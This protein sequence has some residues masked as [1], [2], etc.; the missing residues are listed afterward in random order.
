MLGLGGTVSQNDCQDDDGDEK[1]AYARKSYDHIRIHFCSPFLYLRWGKR[2]FKFKLVEASRFSV[3]EGSP[4]PPFGK[5][6][7]HL[8]FI[9]ISGGETPPLQIMVYAPLNPN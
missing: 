9:K 8:R 2:M 4:L 6:H 1:D 7:C 3:G 5:T